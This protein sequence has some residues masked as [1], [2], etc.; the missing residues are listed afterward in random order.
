MRIIVVFVVLCL[1]VLS[2]TKKKSNSLDHFLSKQKKYK[3][4]LTFLPAKIKLNE[5]TEGEIT[6]DTNLKSLDTI[7]NESDILKRY[8]F[9]L[10]STDSVKKLNVENIKKVDHQ[11]FVDSNS[12]GQFKFHTVFKKEGHVTFNV[13]IEDVLFLKS[14][15]T[16]LAMEVLKLKYNRR[17]GVEISPNN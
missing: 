1:L 16:S 3:I 2:C 5:N 14:K 13:V 10:F 15:D 17:F 4:G 8:I 11:V 12:N 7:I 6:F 9:L